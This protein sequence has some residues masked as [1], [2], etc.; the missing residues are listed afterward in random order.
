[1]VSSTIK[2]AMERPDRVQMGDSILLGAL[3]G[4]QTEGPDIVWM[5]A[6]RLASGDSLGRPQE[7]LNPRGGMFWWHL[8]DV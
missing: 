4:L 1:M 6:A 7:K 5:S 8:R 3:L 2:L